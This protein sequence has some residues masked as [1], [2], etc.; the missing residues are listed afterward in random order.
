MFCPGVATGMTAWG[1]I[2]GFPLA[3]FCTSLPED[4]GGWYIG[5]IMFEIVKSVVLYHINAQCNYGF[6]ALNTMTPE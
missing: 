1:P 4:L 5:N 3:A 2:I 6:I